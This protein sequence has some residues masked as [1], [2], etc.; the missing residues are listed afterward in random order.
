M[1][2]TSLAAFASLRNELRGIIAQNPKPFKQRI[3]VGMVHGIYI[4]LVANVHLEVMVACSLVNHCQMHA[5]AHSN[6]C[7]RSVKIL[8]YK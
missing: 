6:T 2:C 8:D 5:C 3:A 1:Y 7:T 4:G